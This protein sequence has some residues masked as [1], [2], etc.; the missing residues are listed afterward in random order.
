MGVTWKRAIWFGIFAFTTGLVRPE[1]VFLAGFMLCSTLY[2]VRERRLPLLVSFGLIFAICGGIYF[3]WRLHYFGYAFPNPYYIKRATH[4]QFSLLKISTRILIELLL[5]LLP[6]VGLGI[7]SRAA[8]RQ[9]TIWLITIVPFTAIWMIVSL[10]NNHF[11]RFQYVMVPL[12]LLSL[13]GVVAVWWNDLKSTRPELVEQVK[14]PVLG[15]TVLLFGIAIFYN[16][17]LYLGSYSNVG[18]QQLALRLKPYAAKNYTMVVTEAGD[19]PFYS[20]WRAIDAFGLNDA[21]IAHHNNGIVTE[22]YLESYRPEMIMYH[23]WA[24]YRTVPEFHAQAGGEPVSTSDK[25]TEDDIILNRYAVRHGYILAALWGENYCDYHKFW[26]RPDFA[27][28]AAIVSAIR[29]HPYYMQGT[30]R[31]AYDFRNAPVPSI[32]CS[33]D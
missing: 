26:V 5:P 23:V 15:V 3:G 13:G 22:A 32:L 12:S 29:D 1:G 2:G 11:S 31:L 27:D 19:I 16:M 20:E 9:L 18:G 10:D 8:F 4:P 7:R 28:S 24:E 14:L 6:L 17:H 33:V 30:G 25:L 21:Y